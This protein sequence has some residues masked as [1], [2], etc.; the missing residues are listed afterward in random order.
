[1]PAGQTA[2]GVG[3]LRKRKTNRDG[4]VTW[5]WSEDDPTATY[6]VTASN[7]QFDYSESSLRAGGRNI[8]NYNAIDP[9]AHAR[10]RRPRWRRRWAAP[11]R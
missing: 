8:P 6:L 10:S 2:L 4:T 11:R 5:S 7:G 3:E 9:S 1:M